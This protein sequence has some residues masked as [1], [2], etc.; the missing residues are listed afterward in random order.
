MKAIAVACYEKQSRWQAVS[1][2]DTQEQE[3]RPWMN[4]KDCTIAQRSFRINR[5]HLAGV[6]SSYMCL[7]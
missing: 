2:K 6:G 1:R 5:I 4:K 3:M 7:F